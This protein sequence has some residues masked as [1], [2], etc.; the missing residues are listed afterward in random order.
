MHGDLFLA[1][2]H[3]YS[4]LSLSRFLVVLGFLISQFS[5]NKGMMRGPVRNGLQTD[6]LTFDVV[7][8]TVS[9]IQTC[10]WPRSGTCM[11]DTGL[12]LLMRVTTGI[13]VEY[14]VYS[15]RHDIVQ[16]LV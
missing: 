9:W 13:D 14:K 5:A 1:A 3:I 4:K 11:S 15:Q 6:A 16:I 7:W 2:G 12:L 8:R 10:H